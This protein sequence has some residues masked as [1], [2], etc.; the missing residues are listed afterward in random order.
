MIGEIRDFETAQ[1]AI[2]A[3]LTGHLVL[4]TVHTNDAPSAVTRLIDMGVEPFLLSARACSACW[5]SAWCASSASHCR[6]RRRAAAASTR[7]AATQC[8][9]TGYKGRTGVYELMVVD[10]EMRALIHSRAAESG[11]LRR[12]RGDRPAL[13]ARGRR[14]AGRRRHHVARRSD[15]RHP[16]MMTPTLRLRVAAP[17]RRGGS[18][19]GDGRA[20]SC[21]PTF[22]ALDAAGKAHQRPARGR[23]RQGRAL[24]AARAG[25]GAA[26]RSTQVGRRRHRRGR[27]LRFARR[28][29]NSTSLAVW[30]RQLAGLVGSGPAAG[31]RADRAGRRGRGPAPARAGGAPAQRGQRRL[32]VRARAGA[33]RRA[34]STTSTAASSPPASRAARSAACSSA[35]PTTSRSA[36]RCKRQADRRD[37]LPG[38]RLGDRD[39]HRD[40]PRHLRRAAGG[41]ACSPA[42]KRALPL[43]TV[44]DAR[45]SAPSCA[46]GAGWSLLAVAGGVG[47]LLMAL[48]NE[49]FRERFDAG[50]LDLPLI[51]RLSRGYNAARFAG[52]LAMLAGAGV[53]ILKA[54]QAAAETLSQPRDA[55]RRD[56]RAGAGARRRAARLGAGR[57]EALPRPAGD[58]RAPRRA[59]RPAADDAASAPPSSSAAEVQRRAM[60]MATI[61]EPLLIVGDGRRRDADRA[62]RAAADHPA[63]QFVK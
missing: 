49:A 44:G 8:G 22:E 32:A 4:A 40:L 11:D 39:R 53:P 61:L 58:V 3:S 6:K 17:R 19:A 57:Q 38:D 31:A 28:V 43:L 20:E 45:R 2:Q 23:Q 54:L 47:A 27:R 56:G 30:T 59:D 51:G 33:A 16:R 12:R 21:P 50:W 7:S 13:D 5:R 25:A 34:S 63:Q 15:A 42:R 24:A 41:D 36:R 52:T 60:Q 1:I 10:D 62:G 37:A 48:R 35:S 46:T 55:R 29:F 9:K 18:G 26:R 14:A